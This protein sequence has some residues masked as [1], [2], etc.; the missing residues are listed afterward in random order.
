MAET[1]Q[2]LGILGNS[3]GHQ[4]PAV[5]EKWVTNFVV[6]RNGEASSTKTH[7]ELGEEEFWRRNRVSILGFHQPSPLQPWDGLING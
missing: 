3:G 4:I 7:P 6:T 5:S 2:K 1:I